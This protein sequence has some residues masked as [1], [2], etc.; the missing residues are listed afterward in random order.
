MSGFSPIIT[1]ASLKNTNYLKS[2]GATHVLDR[3][4]PFSQ[5]ER[6]VQ[7]IT[8]AP[9]NLIYD[10]VSIRET[11][12]AAWR[13][14]GPQGKLV[15]TLPPVV[16]KQPDDRRGIVLTNGNPHT[17]DN[18]ETGRQLWLHLARLLGNGDIIVSAALSQ[19]VTQS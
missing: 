4:L 7:R 2:I 17:E 16:N 3:Y 9:I 10:T 18:W 12:E 14:L 11:Q 13:L 8:N 19:D 15:L 6:E 1:T 5:L